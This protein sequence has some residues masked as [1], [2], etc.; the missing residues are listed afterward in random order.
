MLTFHVIEFHLVFHLSF[1]AHFNGGAH[2]DLLR[3]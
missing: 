3:N 2:F 1:N